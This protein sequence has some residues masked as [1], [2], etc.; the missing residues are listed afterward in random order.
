MKTSKHFEILER[1]ATKSIFFLISILFKGNGLKR[2]LP[3]LYYNNIHALKLNQKMK[4]K[5]N[6]NTKIQKLGDV[7]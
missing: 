6:S 1:G 5:H 7:K 2:S 4:I 3:K